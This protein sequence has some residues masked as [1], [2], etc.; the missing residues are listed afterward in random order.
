N[1]LGFVFEHIII[2]EKALGKPIPLHIEVCH[3][4]GD[5]LDNSRGNLVVGPKGY[6]KVLY[7]RLR[8]LRVCGNPNARQCQFCRAWGV[9]DDTWREQKS[10]KSA[11]HN[12]C[13]AAHYQARKKLKPQIPREKKPRRPKKERVLM[14]KYWALLRPDHPKAVTGYVRE[15][16]LIAEAALGKP[17]PPGAVVHHVN[18]DDKDNSRGNHVICPSHEYHALLHYRLKALRACGN[19]N[20]L[21][22]GKCK[23]WNAPDEFK[24]GNAKSGSRPVSHITCPARKRPAQFELMK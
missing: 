11:Y 10:S 5:S 15:H 8:A 6:S 14:G 19:P 4:N 7:K 18:L 22:C 12:D 24:V 20:Y 13:S 21:W 23:A 3:P 2:A 1:S 17:L 9:P 16:I